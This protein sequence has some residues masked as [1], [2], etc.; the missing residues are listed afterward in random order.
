MR[1][2]IKVNFNITTEGEEDLARYSDQADFLDFAKD[3]DGVELMFFGEDERGIIPA[4]LVIGYHMTYFITWLDLWRG[5]MAALEKEFG[6]LKAAEAR[7][8]GLDRQV[9]LKRF[10][11][12]LAHAKAYHP[13]YLVFHVAENY[14]DES[15]TFDYSKSDEEVID[16]VAELLNI[17]LADEDGS[18]AFLMENLWEPGLNLRN[19]EMVQRLMDKVEYPNKGIMLDTGHLL[20]TD[21]DIQTQDQAVEFIHAKLDQLDECGDLTR[22]IRGMHLHQSLTGEYCKSIQA[23]PPQ[24]GDKPYQERLWNAYANA[25]KV[26]LHQPFTAAGVG[27]ILERLPL[28]YVTFEF[29]TGS[30]EQHAQYLEDQWNALEGT[31]ERR[32]RG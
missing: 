12:D 6:S 9:I 16:G 21:F 17:L 1:D 8:G 23:N 5:D 19:P 20:H 10:Q 29:I 22:Y 24:D 4:D 7:Y 32:S 14:L 18:V 26:D 27:S 15:Y 25:F 13:Q 11:E 31:L 28:E 3:F 2:D 30:R